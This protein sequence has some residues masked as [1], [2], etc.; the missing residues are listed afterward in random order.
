MGFWGGWRGWSRKFEKL[1]QY[2]GVFEMVRNEQNKE[3][4]MGFFKTTT[5]PT[6]SAAL[7]RLDQLIWV[8]IYGGLLTVVLGLFVHRSDALAGW[9]MLGLGGLLAPVGAVLVYV[10]SR[11]SEKKAPAKS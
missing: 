10:R 9:V 7:R 8:L 11:L 3:L 1:R 2:L 6:T 5:T 4:N